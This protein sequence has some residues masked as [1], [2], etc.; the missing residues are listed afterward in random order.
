MS[1]YEKY[2]LIYLFNKLDNILLDDLMR[3]CEFV[4]DMIKNK[5]RRIVV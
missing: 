2:R 5:V 1:Q 4:L 3:E